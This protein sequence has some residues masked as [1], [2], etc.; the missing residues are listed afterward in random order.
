MS[1]YSVMETEIE[2]TPSQPSPHTMQRIVV[3]EVFRFV[4]KHQQ[5]KKIKKQ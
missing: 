4:Q 3:N 5:Y 2:Q 1:N